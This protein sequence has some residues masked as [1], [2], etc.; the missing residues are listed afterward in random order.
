MD[1]DLTPVLEKYIDSHFRL[2]VKQYGIPSTKEKRDEI[3]TKM[4]NN[5]TYLF[6]KNNYNFVKVHNFLVGKIIIY[7]PIFA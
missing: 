6:K 7:Y 3:Y 1:E 5:T 4:K 2:Y